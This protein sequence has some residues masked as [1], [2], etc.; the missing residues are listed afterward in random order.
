MG[1]PDRGR[2]IRL[3]LEV[4]S[5]TFYVCSRNYHVF[6]QDVVDIYQDVVDF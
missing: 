5:V 6:S 4:E 2:R 3:S 1:T